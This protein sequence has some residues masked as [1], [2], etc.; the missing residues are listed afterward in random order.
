MSGRERHD[1]LGQRQGMKRSTR[2][3]MIAG[4]AVFL[5]LVSGVSFAAWTASSTKTA[6]ATAGAVSVT[7]GTIAGAATITA[8]GP[9][10]YTATNQTV[11]KPITVR[12]TGTVD[13]SVASIVIARSGTLGGNQVA[14][15]FWAGASSACAATTPVV[16]T[17]LSGGTVALSSL[18]MTVAATGSAILC[19]STTFTGSMTTQAGNATS[20]TF[21]VELS[22]GTNWNATD[23][24]ASASRTFTQAIFASSA[25]NPPTNTQ[26]VNQGSSTA[27]TI[28]WSTPSGFSTPNGGYN[29]Y[30]NGGL[31]GNISSTSVTISGNSGWGNLTV[32]AVAS[33]GTE[34]VDSANI[35]IEPR[36]YNRGYYGIS[37]AN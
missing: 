10:T 18:N 24:M 14:V 26:C 33:D 2:L 6:T 11:T 15:K 17:T 37:C 3:S 13:A 20:A 32:R 25:P 22:A 23:A 9:F 28:S 1:V 36:G 27:I 31:L 5:T 7:T 19:A 30:Y 29:I 21:T 8:L 16:S 34:S 4:V 35:P 12:N